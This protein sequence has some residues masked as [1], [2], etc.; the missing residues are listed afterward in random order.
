MEEGEGRGSCPEKHTP[1]SGC[2][3]LFGKSVA[4]SMVTGVKIVG[5]SQGYSV[6]TAA[7]CWT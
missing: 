7:D 4:V 3:H 2:L 1:R 5:M 6:P